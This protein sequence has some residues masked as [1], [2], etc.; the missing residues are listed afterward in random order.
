MH[1]ARHLS[2][3]HIRAY[4]ARHPRQ[5]PGA[6]DMSAL[7]EVLNRDEDAKDELIRQQ[8]CE[9]ARLRAENEALRARLKAVGLDGSSSV[10]RV[11]SGAGFSSRLFMSGS[12]RSPM[13]KIA[14]SERVGGASPP[15]TILPPPRPLSEINSVAAPYLPDPTRSTRMRTWSGSMRSSMSMPHRMDEM[16]IVR[17]GGPI[18]P[19]LRGTTSD[20]GGANAFPERKTLAPGWRMP[21]AVSSTTLSPIPANMVSDDDVGLEL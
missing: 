9:I 4:G 6:N 3:H 8:Q 11:S 2:G 16:D 13:A 10:R 18:E 15:T 5:P 12:G 21:S 1:V 17:H 20:G 19:A 14:R 7:A